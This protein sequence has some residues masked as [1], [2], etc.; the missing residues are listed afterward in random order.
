MAAD[1]LGCRVH[2]RQR[3]PHRGDR[4]GAAAGRF[5]RQGR[6]ALPRRI[7][8]DRQARILEAGQPCPVGRLFAW[9]G[10]SQKGPANIRGC[11]R[12]NW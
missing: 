9:G 3:D 6:A 11:C 5:Q 1:F 2:D 7:Q 10:Y 8:L 4:F 12:H